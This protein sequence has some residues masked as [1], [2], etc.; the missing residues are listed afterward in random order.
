MA[1]IA[2]SGGG[3]VCGVGHSPTAGTGRGCVPAVAGA[4]AASSVVRGAEEVVLGAVAGCEEGS[5]EDRGA[6]QGGG[7]D[8]RG[9]R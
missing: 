9:Q 1:R 3:A 8:L 5:A 6:A 2:G 7:V 4:F